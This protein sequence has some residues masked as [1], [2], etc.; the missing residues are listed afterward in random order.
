MKAIFDCCCPAK[1]EVLVSAKHILR[2][3]VIFGSLLVS[4]ASEF[5]G[6]V[7]D[8]V[9]S[10]AYQISFKYVGMGY[11]WGGQD[12]WYTEEG[13]VDCSGLAINIYKEACELHGYKL[14]F[15]DT[16]TSDLH[17]RYTIPVSDPSPGDLIFMGD[18]GL[19]SHVAIFHRYIED[20]IE[21]L[22]AYSISA[23]VGIRQYPASDT[24]FISFGRMIK[25]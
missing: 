14:P 19:V 3:L 5:H 6:P 22:D 2:L 4:C 7:A 16:T 17:Y 23:L 20:R 24:R 11:K 15:E 21:F 9:V 12:F 10:D 13:T 1:E 8:V 18:D 25:K